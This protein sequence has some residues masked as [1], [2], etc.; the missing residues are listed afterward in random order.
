MRHVLYFIKR[1]YAFNGPILF[2]NLLGMVFISLLDGVGVFLLFSIIGVSGILDVQA[3]DSPL[4]S[5]FL[6][7]RS[8]PMIWSLA[9]ILT[10]YL[11]LVVGQN[12]LQ[13]NLTI[14]N[15]VMQQA[16]TQQLRLDTYR[17]LLQT[18]WAFFV[19][20][21]K[22]DL[23]NSMT[24]EISRVSGGMNTS[25]QLISSFIFTLIQIGIALWLSY[26]LTVFVL[27][28]G[29]AL[30]FFSRKF[31]KKAKKLGSQT[32]ELSMSYLS[33]ISEQLQGIKDIKSNTLEESRIDWLQS[34]LGRMRHEHDQYTRLRTSSQLVYKVASAFLISA[35]IFLSV[36]LF[37]TQTEELLII[38]LI[39]SR[40]W[41]K[42]TG[43]QSSMEQ[44]ASSIP[45]IQ[46]VMRLQEECAGSRDIIHS[47][48]HES[49]SEVFSMNQGIEF[50]QVNFRYKAEEPV[51]AL[52]DISFHIPVNRMTAIVGPSGSGKSTLIDLLMGLMQPQ[53]GTVLID[54]TPLT[55]QRLLSFRRALSYVAQDPFLYNASI[56]DNFLLVDQNVSEK[57]MWEALQ[58]ASA[59]EF[60]SKLPQ[61]LDTLIGDRGI[62]LSG[63]ERQR[64]VLARAILR[65]PSI[66]VLDEAT[67]A[68]DSE[69]EMN[70]QEALDRLKGS[71][72]I[73]VIAH[74]LST[75]RNADQV[76]VLDQG[77]L[78]QT[79]GF[80]QLAGDKRGL[81]RKLLRNQVR[82]NYPLQS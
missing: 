66:L 16:F 67:S 20:K 44:L 29:L 49:E 14:R 53:E 23:V 74:R 40:L 5:L 50:R 56:R 11:V 42:F 28:C 36:V 24:T 17:S 43:I 19:Q 51:Y 77:S 22:S 71:M 31:I 32:S 38:L 26:Q 47:E 27:V 60:I 64:L 37:H 68:L 82:L 30:A 76:L 48:A 57:D 18:N 34:L 63:G 10:G 4:S 70:I 61:G 72:T 39:F 6:F 52:K 59:G 65:K 35:F 1:L 78:I 41:P 58:F 54:G 13:R 21:R 80:N 8:F 62:R 33:G 79:G 55:S 2:I 45:A 81:F 12:V 75:I 73:I 15:A 3:S 7:L 25:L 46:S 69:N 9:F